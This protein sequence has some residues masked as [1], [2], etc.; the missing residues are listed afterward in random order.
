MPS[1]LTSMEKRNFAIREQIVA[2]GRSAIG[3][4]F[5]H[6]GR[7]PGKGLDCVGLIVFVGRSL[8]LF[9]YDFDGYGRLPKRGELQKHILA[10]GFVPIDSGLT[11]PGDILLMRFRKLPQHTAIV[12]DKGMLHAH[13]RSFAVVEHGIDDYWKQRI[14]AGY[15]F[16]GID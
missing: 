15:Q 3:T 9:D 12:T 6:Q 5:K 13:M 2:V 8:G 16:P 4:P 11:V 14:M 10:A 7:Q 1:S